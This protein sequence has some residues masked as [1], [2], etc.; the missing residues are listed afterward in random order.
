MDVLN[1]V[2]LNSATVLILF[3]VGFIGGMVSGFI[4]SGGAFVLKVAVLPVN[5]TGLHPDTRGETV[6]FRLRCGRCNAK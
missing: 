4:G 2:E 1:F 6:V 5:D 3:V